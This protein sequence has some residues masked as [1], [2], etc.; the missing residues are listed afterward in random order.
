[1]RIQLPQTVISWLNPMITLGEERRPR[2]YRISSRESRRVAALRYAIA[3]TLVTV[4]L[5]LRKG[6]V[7][8]QS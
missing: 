3:F 2:S 6:V 1:M 5:A 8:C 7:S 4:A